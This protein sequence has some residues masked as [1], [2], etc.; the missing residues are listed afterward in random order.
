MVIAIISILAAMLMPA[1]EKAREKA[2]RVKCVN[3]LKQLFLALDL[4]A[5]NNGEWYPHGRWGESFCMRVRSQ[6][7]VL[8][9]DYGVRE[10]LVYC[11]S[12][13]EFD[14][15]WQWSNAGAM[16]YNYLAGHGGHGPAGYV[17]WGWV[18][19]G[20]Y[21]P[22]LTEGIKPVANRYIIEK[23]SKNPMVFDC[24]YNAADAANHYWNRPVRSN[25]ANSDGTAL[26]QNMLYAD[27]HVAWVSL[28]HGISE[29]GRFAKDYYELFYW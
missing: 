26:G 20:G 12:A 25:H 2:Q 3:N 4:Y 21:W 28:D 24:S 8:E 6:R 17:S 15:G 9:Q 14:G 13:G 5:S 7:R 1:L 23:A 18:Y 16:H 27:G 11:P 29:K 22:S 10:Q 19:N